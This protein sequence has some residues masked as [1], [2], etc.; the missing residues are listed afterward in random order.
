MKAQIL[1]SVNVFN[2]VFKKYTAAEFG[3]LIEVVA[4]NGNLNEYRPYD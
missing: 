4:M 1:S 2:G 3:L